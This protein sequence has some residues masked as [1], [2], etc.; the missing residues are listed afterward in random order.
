MFQQECRGF[1]NLH[2]H[3]MKNWIRRRTSSVQ[4]SMQR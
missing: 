3:R 4:S 2:H 1:L